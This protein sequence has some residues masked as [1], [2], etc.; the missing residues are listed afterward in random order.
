MSLSAKL[1]K[2]KKIIRSYGDAVIAFSGGLDSSFL[3][4]VASVVLP[5]DK[6]IAVTGNSHTY[7][8]QELACARRVARSFGVRHIVVS[9]G[10]L[11]DKRFSLNRA[12][13]CYYC[14]KE[15]FS[16]LKRIARD[17]KIKNVMDAS[18]LSDK[19]DFRP[20]TKAKLESGARSP[21]QEAGLNKE[22]IRKLSRKMGLS[23]WD[24]PAAACL[25]SRI[26]YGV[27]I[28]TALLNR[29]EA[30]EDFLSGIGFKQ[31]R[32]RHHGK[33][34]R[35][36]VLKKEIPRIFLKSKAIVDKLKRLGYNYVTVDL[37]GYR[38]GSL[39]EVINR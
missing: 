8:K 13:R 24:K 3:L 19:A 7:P 26:P 6:V 18:N 31:V 25:A 38:T 21:L 4:Y 1:G 15:L 36:E 29:I 11:K 16:R 30:A 39:N 28:G 37:E 27:A 34:C 5:G 14:K 20:G 32:L 12:N 35:I 2:L 10:E 22:D 33:L 23:F 9:T 17:N